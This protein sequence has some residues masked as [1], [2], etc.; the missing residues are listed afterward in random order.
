MT[1]GARLDLTSPAHDSQLRGASAA[2][3]AD[4][5]LEIVARKQ[6]TIRRIAAAKYDVVAFVNVIVF[7]FVSVKSMRWGT[8]G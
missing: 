8:D 6:K 4:D 2:E 5:R 1:L 3:K 7:G